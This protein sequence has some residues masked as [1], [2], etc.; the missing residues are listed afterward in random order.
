MP[1]CWDWLAGSIEQQVNQIVRWL[2][3]RGYRS[4]KN[5]LHNRS[6][7]LMSPL[8]LDDFK[9][10][11]FFSVCF[12]LFW[13]DGRFI[14][15]VNNHWNVAKFKIKYWKV[16]GSGF[17]MITDQF[18]NFSISVQ[19]QRIFHTSG[20]DLLFAFLKKAKHSNEHILKILHLK[21][22]TQLIIIKLFH[23][24]W[25]RQL[26]IF[27]VPWRLLNKNCTVN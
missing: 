1:T 27:E 9:K 7:L 11:G 16:S 24:L 18:D 13:S 19:V 25:K 23:S 14:F 3:A 26:K 20:L 15:E 5:K 17:S 10:S 12:L 4:L 2:A 22:I 8:I 6:H 21:G